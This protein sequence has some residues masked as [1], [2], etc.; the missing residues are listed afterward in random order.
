MN[1]HDTSRHLPVPPPTCH[2]GPLAIGQRP[3]LPA[4]TPRRL[5]ASVKSDE[6][7]PRFSRCTRHKR[8]HPRWEHPVANP[9]ITL[10][11]DYGTNDHLAGTLKGVILKVVPDATIVDITHQVNPFDLLDGAL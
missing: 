3:P 4:L 11:T 2:F 1:F 9:I 7:P 6:A 10:T 8:Q 5:S